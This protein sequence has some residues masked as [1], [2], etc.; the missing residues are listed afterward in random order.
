MTAGGPLPMPASGWDAR[1]QRG[2]PIFSYGECAMTKLP[3]LC[4]ALLLFAPAACRAGE[5]Y[6]IRPFHIDGTLG[7]VE[8]RLIV[9][10]S[11]K[12][13]SGKAY[14]KWSLSPGWRAAPA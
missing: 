2:N 5:P 3:T 8:G 6:R 7:V 10:L 9:G 1:A 12:L 14:T 11:G 4:L 13:R